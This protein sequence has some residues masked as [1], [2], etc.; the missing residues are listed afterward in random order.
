VLAEARDKRRAQAG[1]GRIGRH[2]VGDDEQVGLLADRADLVGQPLERAVLNLALKLLPEWLAQGMG[3][4]GR[5][6]FLDCLEGAA[7]VEVG[8]ENAH[9]A[10]GLLC[11]HADVEGCPS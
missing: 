11:A 6:R 4:E 3:E 9:A 8:M 5:A 1:Q 7:K 10:K 2:G